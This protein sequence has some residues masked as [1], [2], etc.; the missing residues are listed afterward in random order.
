MNDARTV[1]TLTGHVT[2]EDSGLPMD[3]AA[4]FHK[5]GVESVASLT[6]QLGVGTALSTAPTGILDSPRF[7]YIEAQKPVRVSVWG[8]TGST[9]N[10]LKVRG[11][12][13]MGMCYRTTAVALKLRNEAAYT[14]GNIVRVIGSNP[15]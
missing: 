11:G 12:L 7:L 5:V 14:D 9:T 15:Q 13:V 2:V 3:V 1:V 4:L 6:L 10:T 8:Y